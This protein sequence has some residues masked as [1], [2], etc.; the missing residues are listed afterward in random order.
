MFNRECL[1]S[2]S[3]Q[4]FYENLQITD[5]NLDKIK[6][7]LLVENSIF[8]FKGEKKNLDNFSKNLST[9]DDLDTIITRVKIFISHV[10]LEVDLKKQKK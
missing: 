10:G 7:E 1:K 4:G 5:E 2:L 3:N 9:K 6:R 8:S